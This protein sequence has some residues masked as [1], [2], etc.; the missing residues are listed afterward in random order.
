MC[1]GLLEQLQVRKNGMK[2]LI[3][4]KW[5]TEFIYWSEWA[6]KFEIKLYLK[7]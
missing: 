7:K 6:E 2:W 4:I 1:L 3:E 5:I